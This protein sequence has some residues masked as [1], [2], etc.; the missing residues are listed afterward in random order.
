MAGIPTSNI[1]QP[2][3]IAV[4]GGVD[5]ALISNLQLLTPQYYNKYVE[6]Y[7][8]EAYDYFFQWL[9]TFGGMETVKNRNFFWF[10]SRGK[11]QIAVTN[12]T[13]V[14]GPAAGA[15]VTVNIPASDLYDSGTDSP[16]RVG[17]TVYVA[18]SNIEGEILTVPS[19]DQC[20]IRPKQSDQIGRA[21]V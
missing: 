17:E 21:H 11:N 12:L 15:T 1:L 19:P 5:R 16:L 18:S 20:T 3:V 7:G 6:K 4:S 13:Q 2:G 10:E 9:A 14:T 8:P